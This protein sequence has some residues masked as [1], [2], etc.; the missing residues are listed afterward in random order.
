MKR[1]LAAAVL[2]ALSFA[3]APAA[4]SPTMDVG[5]A[6]D[7]LLL[8]GTDAEAAGAV[9]EWRAAGVDVVRIHARWNTHAVDPD[10]KRPPAGSPTDPD[11]G[12]YR[13]QDLDRAIGLVRGAGLRVLLTVTGPGPLWGSSDPSRGNPRFKPDPEKFAWFATAVARRYGAFV[14]DYIIWNEPN[15]EQWLQPQNVCG[16]KGC[17]PYAPHL[18]RRLVRAADPAIRAADPGARTMMGALAPSGTSGRSRN[19][20]LRPLAFLRALGCV[21]ARYRRVRSGECR[22]FQPASAYGFAYHPHGILKSPTTRS[23]NP[24]DAQLADLPR[25]LSAIDRV[26]RAGGLRSRAPNGRFPLYLDEYGYQTSPPDRFLGV[27]WATQAA[28]LSQSAS[29]AWANPRVRNLTN[30]V[31]EDEPLG[32]SGSG[33]QSGLKTVDGAVKDAYR[34]FVAPFWATR[35]T[36]GTVRVWG[37]ARPG[38]AHRVQV[39]RRGSGGTWVRVAALTTDARGAF[40]KT[41]SLRGTQSLRFTWDAGTSGTRTVGPTP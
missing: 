29:I 37:Q 15:H 14:D 13:W 23:P 28:W 11:G 17:T 31:W 40:T 38:G 9:R 16:A 1:C 24:D 41:L 2:A 35:R 12:L 5:I 30:Y 3:A 36:T 8:S 10:A 33:W 4:A 21:D 22:G 6:D 25:L 34:S 7:R 39:S 26:T 19:A 27:S 18:Y 32:A 20:R